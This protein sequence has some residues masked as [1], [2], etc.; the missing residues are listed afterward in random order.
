MSAHAINAAGSRQAKFMMAGSFIET[1][2]RISFVR[3]IPGNGL[4]IPETGL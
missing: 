3:T 4:T 1:V 2:P